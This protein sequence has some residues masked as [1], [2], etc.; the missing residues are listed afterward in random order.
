M[1]FVSF[2]VCFGAVR[3]TEKINCFGGVVEAYF[4][5]KLFLL[6]LLERNVCKKMFELFSGCTD[7]LMLY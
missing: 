7:K 5:L 4:L 2:F 1:D 6:L 3:G